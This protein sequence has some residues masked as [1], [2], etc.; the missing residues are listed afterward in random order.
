MI[1]AVVFLVAWVSRH[2]R[3]ARRPQEALRDPESNFRLGRALDGR[4]D[5]LGGFRCYLA[6]AQGGL[7]VAAACIWLAYRVGHGV[8]PDPLAAQAWGQRATELGWPD[9]LLAA[10]DGVGGHGQEAEMDP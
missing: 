6:A 2:L 7:P 1:S 3:R 4:R 9:V 10:G 5:A 8:H